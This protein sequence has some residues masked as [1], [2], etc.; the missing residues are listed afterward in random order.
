MFSV[1]PHPLKVHNITSKYENW[2][3]L[4]FLHQILYI[5][6][7]KLTTFFLTRKNGRRKTLQYS[8]YLV[9]VMQYISSD[10]HILNEANGELIWW[11]CQEC[12]QE[13]FIK[14]DVFV[15]WEECVIGIGLMSKLR[16]QSGPIETLLLFVI[17]LN[18][19]IRWNKPL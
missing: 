18:Y 1:H 12:S 19:T 2:I 6:K 10:R 14:V 4:C 17:R 16:K 13:F 15:L 8:Q 9:V 3:L 7:W 5:S 11:I